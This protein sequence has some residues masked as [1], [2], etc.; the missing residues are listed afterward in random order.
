MR[1]N[2]P[3]F[4]LL[5]VLVA[6]VVLALAMSAL[7]R[8]TALQADG[9]HDARQR[10]YAQWVAA[11]AITDARLGGA[12]PAQGVREGEMAMGRVRWRWRMV[13]SPT[14]VAGIRRLD[15]GVRAA[16]GRQVLVLSGF[17]GSR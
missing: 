17:A 11:N 5:E 15:V 13:V 2:A 1:A 3:G 4:T 10:T 8:T 9:L 16:D 12:L 14:A 6:L 7:V